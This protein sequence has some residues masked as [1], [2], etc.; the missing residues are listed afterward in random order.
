MHF[1]VLNLVLTDN[2]FKEAETHK[3]IS[4]TSQPIAH[5]RIFSIQNQQHCII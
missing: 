2:N 4:Y 3:N 1:F 5:N